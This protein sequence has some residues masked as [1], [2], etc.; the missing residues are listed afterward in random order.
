MFILAISI[1]VI[2]P[3]NKKMKH[4]CGVPYLIA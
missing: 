4:S 2:F 1:S 3:L